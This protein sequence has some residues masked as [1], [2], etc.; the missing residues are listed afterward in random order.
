MRLPF[1]STSATPIIPSL[2]VTPAPEM[3]IGLDHCNIEFQQEIV[4]NSATDISCRPDTVMLQPQSYIKLL[5]Q[6]LTCREKHNKGQ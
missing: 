4:M 2:E 5:L 1:P 6:L 3:V